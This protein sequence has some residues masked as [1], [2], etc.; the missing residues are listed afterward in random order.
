MSKEPTPFEIKCEILSD[1]WMTYRTDTQFKD[2]IEYNDIGLP[3]AFAAS[4]D[5]VAIN[6]RGKLFIN[7]AFDLLLASLDIKEDTGFESL[8]DLL[9]G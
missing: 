4:E 7:E 9:V 6:E 8:D 5:M 1:L 3:M 2:F